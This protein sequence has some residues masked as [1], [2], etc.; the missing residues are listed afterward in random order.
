MALTLSPSP[1]KTITTMWAPDP[2]RRTSCVLRSTAFA[3]TGPEAT[4]REGRSRRTS[5]SFH[6]HFL[7]RARRR[8]RNARRSPGVAGR[9]RPDG[10]A[11]VAC[12]PTEAL[13]RWERSAAA[14][15]RRVV[16]GSPPPAVTACSDRAA[17]PANAGH[18]VCSRALSTLLCR[19]HISLFFRASDACQLLASF[20][21]TKM[22]MGRG[23]AHDVRVRASCSV[24]LW[25]LTVAHH[26]SSCY[27]ES[28]SSAGGVRRMASHD[29]PPG[30]LCSDPHSTLVTTPSQQ[31]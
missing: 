10:S 25:S 6:H 27:V 18:V 23:W 8:L 3:L 26:S 20:R 16:G 21:R 15:P 14:A 19:Q 24:S 22:W 31:S 2:A 11:Y 12:G 4:K 28:A 9:A 17:A 5:P 30:R 13:M 1:I 7:H 29:L